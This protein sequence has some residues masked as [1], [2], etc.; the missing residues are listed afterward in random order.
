MAEM[1]LTPEDGSSEAST[2]Q[3]LPVE[4]LALI[5]EKAGSDVEEL[6]R[7]TAVSRTFK[8]ATWFVHKVQAFISCLSCASSE[9]SNQLAHSISRFLEQARQIRILDLTVHGWTCHYCMNLDHSGWDWESTVSYWVNLVKDDLK[10]FR[11]ED[12]VEST[13]QLFFRKLALEC[14]VNCQNLERVNL[15]LHS[16]FDDSCPSVFPLPWR[17]VEL[18]LRLF[19]SQAHECLEIL[20]SLPQ[21]CPLLKKLSF[22][23]RFVDEYGRLVDQYG[24][25]RKE[26]CLKFP[27][28]EELDLDIYA[29]TINL[30]IAFV[31]TPKLQRLTYRYNDY[32][33]PNYTVNISL[34]VHHKLL[35]LKSLTVA[36]VS[37]EQTIL[38]LKE[39][40][41]LE[42]FAA[43]KWPETG[44]QFFSEV[45][46]RPGLFT[47]LGQLDKSNCGVKRLWIKTARF[48]L[49]GFGAVLPKLE[50]VH[51]GYEWLD[52][53]DLQ[54]VLGTLEKM[55]LSA[56]SLSEITL[57]A[58]SGSFDGGDLET[59]SDR[60]RELREE[61]PR[62]KLQVKM[63][64]NE[65]RYA[66]A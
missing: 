33:D 22:G 11:Y 17:I 26:V 10:E 18:T 58:K 65:D 1:R 57:H 40:P 49:E 23:G 52:A 56:P 27:V 13:D 36:N 14:L 62:V 3:A 45:Q 28:L 29:V 55:L 64:R 31:S 6:L 42:E 43:A 32:I 48:W 39:C 51:F 35:H 37:L 7:L 53:F 34:A 38:L 66:R 24:D 60:I 30:R 41:N 59:L 44:A 54:I 21:A 5:F 2:I 12:T 20:S 61:F 9:R 16:A 63:D 50:K 4:V 46:L 15:Q 8:E 19:S 47:I 25:A